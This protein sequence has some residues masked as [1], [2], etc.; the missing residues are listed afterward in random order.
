MSDPRLSEQTFGSG[1][2]C[3]GCLLC[4]R[5]PCGT[6]KTKDE[7]EPAVKSDLLTVDVFPTSQPLS[8]A[9]HVHVSLFKR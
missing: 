7:P 8:S 4:L 9:A 2:G 1:R 6:H 5:R 3:S